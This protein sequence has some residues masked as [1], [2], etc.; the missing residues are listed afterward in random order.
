MS[1]CAH[2]NLVDAGQQ[3]MMQQQ[4]ELAVERF[5]AAAKEQP[6]NEDTAQQLARAKAQLNNWAA[7]L[8]QQANLA[9][10][11]QQSE[12]A[13]LLY[14]KVVQL[15]R[16]PTANEH[17]K[18]L[19][20]QLRTDSMLVASL[21]SEGIDIN[22]QL[23]HQTDGLLL[24]QETVA[25]TLKFS[26]SN[27]IFEIQQSTKTLQTQYIS[28]SQMIANPELVKLQHEL[29]Q[30][31]HQ[32]QDT[33]SKINRLARRVRQLQS[34]QHDLDLS[35]NSVEMALAA[36]GLATAQRAQLDQRLTS[37]NS[38]LSRTNHQLSEQQHTVTDLKRQ[39]SQRRQ[40]TNTLAHDLAHV[41]PVV[42]VPVYSDYQYPVQQQTNSLTST[43]YL[44]VNNQIRP[45]NISVEST[46]QSHPDHPTIGLANNPM[47]VSTQQQLTPLLIQQRDNVVRRLLG[48]LVDE[49]KLGFYYQSQQ[50][51]SSDDKLA[52]LIKHGLMTTQGP[53][54]QARDTIQNILILEYGRGGEFD[55]NKLLHLYP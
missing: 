44:T 12:K 17:Y 29:S 37:I 35:K 4:F 1:G 47:V 21:S 31:Q 14:G 2:R 53:I 52:L 22:P 33:N 34:T 40:K 46:D 26:Q 36:S 13:L 24:S 48:E 5:S 45:A 7:N 41:S 9:E 42:E 27:P 16:S 8:E 3:F 28:G 55:I 23:I 18:A 32:Q 39:Q 6:D 43:L 10:T 38:S 50:A 30:K 49:K 51:I 19:Y 15:T 54:A 25:T 11:K 20:Q